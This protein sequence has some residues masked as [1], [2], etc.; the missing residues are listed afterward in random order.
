MEFG[1]N[2]E[3]VRHVYDVVRRYLHG[4]RESSAQELH[5]LVHPGAPVMPSSALPSG[6]IG[7]YYGPAGMMEFWDAVRENWT[8]F[9]L[10]P[11][12]IVDAP[13]DTVVAICRVVA[14]RDDGRGF[15]VQVA[16]VWRIAEGRV[17]G[18][19]SFQSPDQAFENAG[20]KRSRGPAWPGEQP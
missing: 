10:T 14:S 7:P 11:D 19:M 6:S 20:L 17:A 4:E 12:E 5:E 2:A 9:E 15:A 3:L 8:S 1:S 16:H 18:S 13:P